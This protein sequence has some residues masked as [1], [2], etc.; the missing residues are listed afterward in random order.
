[1]SL[2]IEKILRDRGVTKREL[3]EK[4]KIAPQNVSRTIKRLTDNYSEIES[5]LQMIGYDLNVPG[6]NMS[7]SQQRTIENLSE[8]IKNL[9]SKNQ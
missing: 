1:M 2:D 9:T 3:A 5:V 7:A 8:T 6:D 4:L